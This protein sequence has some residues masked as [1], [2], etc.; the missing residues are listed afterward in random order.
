MD[1]STLSDA[2]LLSQIGGGAPAP[3]SGPL[4]KVPDAVLLR[5]LGFGGEK[6]KQPVSANNVVRAA[7]EGIPIVGG[8]L[9]KA[10]A[11][12]NAVL[13]PVVEP[14]LTPSDKDI[15]RKGETLSERYRKSL[16]MQ[17]QQSAD[18]AQE[19][20]V[21]DTA[22]KLTGGVASMVP[23]AASSVAAKALGMTGTL[24]QMVTRGALSS[25]GIGAADAVVRGNDP[26]HEAEVSGVVGAALPVVG[27]GL[28]MAINKFR[29][30]GPRP[31][32]T[33]DVNGVEVPQWES[34]R[35][36]DNAAGS[37]EQAALSGASGPE[38]Q[39]IAQEA[40]DARNAAMTQ[41]RDKFGR[42]LAPATDPALGAAP[43]AAIPTPHQ[44]GE[45]V[46][47]DAAQA[48]NEQMRQQALRGIAGEASDFQTRA[49]LNPRGGPTPVIADTAYDAAGLIGQTTQDA[50]RRSNAARQANYRDLGQIPIE[51]APAGFS[52]VGNSMR[53]R[54]DAGD[55]A[56][57]VRVNDTTP[58]TRNAIQ[59]IEE[60]FQPR[61]LNAAERG[62][63]YTVGP[64]GRPQMKPITG[65]DVE[66]VRQQLIPMIRDANNAA[67][68]PGGSAADARGMRRLVDA[69][70]DHVS[71]LVRNGGVTGNGEAY[72]A[73][74]A[75]ARAGHAQHRG[76]FSARG[77]GDTV[78]PIVER[79][80]G[81]HPGQE[82]TPD[83]IAQAL[84]GQASAPGGAQTVQVAQRLRQIVGPDSA[85]WTAARQ[86]L[87]SHI[88]D[89]PAGTEALTPLVQAERIH[90]LLNS[91]KSRALAQVFFSPAERTQLLAHADRLR[92]LA[93]AGGNNAV[94]RQL[95]RL[96]GMD[97]HP[98]ASSRDVV[99]MLFTGDGTKASGVKLAERLKTTLA[100]ESWD[101]VRQG[102]W[103]HLTTKPEGM[104]EYGPQALSQR[105][106]KFLSEPMAEVLFNGRERQMMKIIADEYKKMIPLA[107][108]TN[109]SGSGVLLS[110]MA[111]AAKG[112]LLPML[113]LAAHGVPGVLAGSAMNKALSFV[114]NRKTVERTKDLFQGKAVKGPVSKNYERAA[115]V[116]SHAAT[117]LIGAPSQR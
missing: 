15:S 4:E 21:V 99:D 92:A 44:A 62:G 39:R 61:P 71:E 26:V 79:I 34:V 74:L 84:Y 77:N 14:F 43:D 66:A 20:P 111:N 87:L 69:F 23:L 75:R 49:A 112:N 91:T 50:A 25:A 95:M 64:D 38:A 59:L 70:D 72:L 8:L 90:S 117:P 51:F 10:N 100:P 41:A 42:E 13:A 60:N 114:S 89:A 35:T 86:G 46:V 3:A 81:K 97:G 78:G 30:A 53:A 98:P 110:K 107:N 103:S 63:D 109:P 57:R 56:Q 104:I 102:M 24:P 76:M 47:T 2:E 22:A 73:Q 5:A 12:T 105:L 36:G 48:A 31:N 65:M 17:D 27:R 54:L 116:L 40:A 96:S 7:G 68:A 29:S 45:Q 37:A 52:R 19:H 11:A 32:P 55:P 16:A 83:A 94:D 58:N 93:P 106:H 113:G 88:L 101:T 9:N 82:S 85:A 28:G 1:Y 67:R 6:E 33:A 115:A 80:I 108:T 18:F